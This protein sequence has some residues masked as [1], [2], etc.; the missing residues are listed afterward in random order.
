MARIGTHADVTDPAALHHRADALDAI[1][2]TSRPPS[3]THS[4]SC[5][6]GSRSH[7]A[8]PMPG[9]H[10]AR[11][12]VC[13]PDLAV[14]AYVIDDFEWRPDASGNRRKDRAAFIGH[15]DATWSRYIGLPNPG[16]QWGRP[17]DTRPIQVLPTSIL[18]E[19]NTPVETDDDGHPRTAIGG[20][21]VTVTND[22]AYVLPPAGGRVVVLSPA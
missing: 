15:E 2:D 21:M 14:S 20:Y 22:G 7:P 16:R 11:P 18:T 17:G 6:R 12:L 10:G 19:P 9:R 3:W 5:G 8:G 1:G 4:P 13:W